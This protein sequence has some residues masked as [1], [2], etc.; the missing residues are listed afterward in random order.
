MPLV[1]LQRCVVHLCFV[2]TLLNVFLKGTRQFPLQGDNLIISA[3]T[4]KCLRE[5]HDAL[6]QARAK[7]LIM[8]GVFVPNCEP[9]GSYSRVQ[10]L[11]T[12]RY[13]WCVD[14]TGGEIQGTRVWQSQPKCAPQPT[15]SKFHA[16]VTSKN[17]NSFISDHY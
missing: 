6:Q 11:N 9:D 5:R 16:A 3:P 1:T 17:T 8:L 15:H 12:S 14:S 10:C 7:D 4:S 13:C 2:L